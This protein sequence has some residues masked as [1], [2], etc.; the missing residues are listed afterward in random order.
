MACTTLAVPKAP[1]FNSGGVHGVV[2]DVVINYTAEIGDKLKQC[3]LLVMTQGFMVPYKWW[4]YACKSAMC[5]TKATNR[6]LNNCKRVMP[7]SLKDSIEMYLQGLI[8]ITSV[9]N[10][11]SSRKTIT[12][13]RG[14][15]Y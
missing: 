2:T 14:E 13:R 15:Q 4:H 7:E 3:L 12:L 9:V 6:C 10:H 8:S 5:Y 11:M 1:F